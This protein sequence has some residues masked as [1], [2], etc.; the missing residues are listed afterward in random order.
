MGIE[1][2]LQNNVTY[3]ESFDKGDLPAVPAERVAVVTCMDARIDVHRILGVREGDVHVIR[4]AGGL[5]TDDAIRS[6]L[7]SQRVLS[8][9]EVLIIQ[10][11]GCGMLNLPEEQIKRDL[12]REFA[13]P[14]SFELGGFTDLHDSVRAAVTTI[15]DTPFLRGAVR[16]FLYDVTNGR[17]HE[18]T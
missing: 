10:H 9:E 2:L 16:G 5:V 3:A 18:V 11:T 8:T 1:D 4:N 12:E 7:L 15:K 6:L 17:L 13:S 14:P